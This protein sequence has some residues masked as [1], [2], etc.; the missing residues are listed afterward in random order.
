MED[1]EKLIYKMMIDEKE[2]EAIKTRW[3]VYE[4]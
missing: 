2:L 1:E 3:E 4:A